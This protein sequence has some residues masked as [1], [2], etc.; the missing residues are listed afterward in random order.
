MSVVKQRPNPARGARA[1][2]STSVRGRRGRFGR[3]LVPLTTAVLLLGLPLVAPVASGAWAEAAATGE[4]AAA[5]AEGPTFSN[6]FMFSPV[7]NSILLALS[8]LSL[9]MFLYL[10]LS[11]HPQGLAPRAFVDEI[12]RLVGDGQYKEAIDFCRG[13]RKLF[14]ASVI[15]R[16]LDNADKDPSVLMAVVDSEGKRRADTIWNS[17]S[18]LADVANVA[19]MLG[20]LGTVLGMIKAF[21]VVRWETV[22]ASTA[23]LASAIGEAMSTTMF[24][25]S[26][27]I[28]ALVFHSVIKSR[29]TRA[30]AEVEQVVHA[31][32]DRIARQNVAAA[33]AAAT[34]RYEGGRKR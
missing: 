21:L 2:H 17:L 9:A 26:V 8:L 19:P 23:P 10:L 7:I 31:V 1:G 29:A 27:A 30:L 13:H 14:A 3:W 4:G 15:R 5:I 25:L 24:G 34:A 18:Y 12:Y 33:P 32:A 22:A 16:C 28:L 20:L 11:V 6:L